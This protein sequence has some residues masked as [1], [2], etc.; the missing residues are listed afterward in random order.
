MQLRNCIFSI[1]RMVMGGDVADVL[2][3]A[4][5]RGP[6]ATVMNSKTKL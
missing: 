1:L 2:V 6:Q 5:F 3:A 4:M